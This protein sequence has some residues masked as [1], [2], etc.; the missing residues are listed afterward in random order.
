MRHGCVGGFELMISYLIGVTLALAVG[1]LA[2]WIGLDRD[3][4]FYPSVTMV[5]AAYYILFAAMD[6]GSAVLIAEIVVGL[7]FIVL[8]LAGFKK[9]LWL[10]VAALAAHGIF[11]HFHPHAIANRGVPVWWPSFCSAYDVTAAAFLAVLLL[12]P[13]PAH[14]SDAG[15][16]G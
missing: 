11:D 5:I 12:R 8:A 16:I 9:S 15:R 3:R 14:A 4:A 2:R 13:R 6:G 7:G 10:V 1:A